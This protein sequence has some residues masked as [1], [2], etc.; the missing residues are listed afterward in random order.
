MKEIK[1]TNG[2][3][4]TVDDEDYEKASKIKWY[5]IKGRNT[6]YATGYD[7]TFKP[8]KT[9]RLHWLVFGKHEKGFVIDHI[10][11]DGLNNEKYNLRKCTNRQNSCNR[12]SFGSSK[13][14][15]VSIV[16][17][18]KIPHWR[19]YLV[20]KYLGIFSSEIEAAK[21]Y[22]EAA[23]KLHGEFAKLNII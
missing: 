21:V 9:M 12:S 13:Y 19:V 22:N 18:R 7:A 23:I 8:K 4:T 3:I 14:L 1:L 6:V 17:K 11:G 16:T 5:P 20:G 10:N 15:G 2:L